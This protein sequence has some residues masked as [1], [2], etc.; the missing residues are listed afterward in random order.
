MANNLSARRVVIVRHP[1]ALSGNHADQ[2]KALADANMKVILLAPGNTSYDLRDN[3]HPPDNV[4][5]INVDYFD[6]YQ[7]DRARR[8][9]SR[10]LENCGFVLMDTNLPYFLEGTMVAK[11]SNVDMLTLGSP[12]ELSQSAVSKVSFDEYEYADDFGA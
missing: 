8:A 1:Q 2:I 5:F 4:V 9:F 7:L 11:P 3:Y 10:E 6:M 12:E